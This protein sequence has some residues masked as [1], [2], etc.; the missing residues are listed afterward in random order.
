[1]SRGGLG[2]VI[3][4]LQ[5]WSDAERDR[6]GRS[7]ARTAS[8]VSCSMSDDA[9]HPS[10]WPIAPDWNVRGVR[11]L[12]SQVGRHGDTAVRLDERITHYTTQYDVRA[13]LVVGHTA[14]EVLAEA[15]DR[16]VA[17]TEDSPAGIEARLAPLCAVVSAG[18]EAGVLSE[19]LPPGTARARLVEFNVHRQSRLLRRGDG[20]AGHPHATP[21]GRGRHRG[22][23]AGLSRRTGLDTVVSRASTRPAPWRPL[24]VN[25]LEVTPRG[26]RPI[27]PAKT[28]MFYYPSLANNL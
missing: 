24:I 8:V 14:C 19:S 6:T 10:P 12:G 18:C 16:W 23:S 27:P 11:T 13:V 26:T 17:P 9:L 15:H 7:D 3:E 28:I 4:S 21:R 25:R 2:S 22:E 5:R 20:P 1:M